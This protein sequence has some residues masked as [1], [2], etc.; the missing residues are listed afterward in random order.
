MGFI[1]RWPPAPGGATRGTAS[2]RG[3]KKG[4]DSPARFVTAAGPAR[5]KRNAARQGINGTSHNDA[6]A[7]LPAAAAP[8]LLEGGALRGLTS[9]SK[10]LG[11]GSVG[12]D[13]ISRNFTNI[14]EKDCN[15]KQRTL[16]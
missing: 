13:S 7:G 4:L 1:S 5:R 16:G 10:S 14:S 8:V 15:R 9:W 11:A 3:A 6:S 12:S 2:E